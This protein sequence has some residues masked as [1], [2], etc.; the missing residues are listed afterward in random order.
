[1][2]NVRKYHGF[3][4]IFVSAALSL[5]VLSALAGASTHGP[6]LPPDPWENLTAA[7]GPNLP[8]DPWENLTAA[9]HGPNLPPDPWEN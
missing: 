4:H 3:S 2:K 8:P 7:H 9:A 6:N 5:T 1:M